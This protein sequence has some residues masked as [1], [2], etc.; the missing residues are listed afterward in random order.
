MTT[1][2]PFILFT[3]KRNE[4]IASEAI[5]AGVTDYMQKEGGTDQYT[6]LANRVRNAVRQ[7]RSEQEA[8]QM[9]RRLKEVTGSSTDCIWMFS[10]DWDELLFI[11]GYEKVWGRPVEQIKQSPQDFLQGVH[12][13]DR[14]F[15]RDA[16]EALSSG[17]SIDIEYRRQTGEDETRWV[18]VKGE[19]VFDDDG[20]VVR[21]VGF[22]RDTT[23][24]KRN[25]RQLKQE[26][27]SLN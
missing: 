4:E 14:D 1:I 15:V 12:P 11:S 24:R 6:V 7:Y 16:M 3:G 9:Q 25:Q 22:T 19:P 5:S 21:V 8:E 13:D 17:E 23:D 18:W 27:A 10:R 20:T 26:R 2:C